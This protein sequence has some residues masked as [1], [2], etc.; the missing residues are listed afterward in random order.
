MSPSFAIPGATG[1]DGMTPCMGGTIPG[2]AVP[3]IPG[4]AIPGGIMPG[5]AIPCKRGVELD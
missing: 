4:G 1:A 5:G 3:S 2:G